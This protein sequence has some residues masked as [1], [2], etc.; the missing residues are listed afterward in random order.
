MKSWWEEVGGLEIDNNV[1]K[2]D[3]AQKLKW[4]TAVLVGD[5]LNNPLVPM[6]GR[7]G[8]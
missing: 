7:T 5:L 1:T 8:Q 6:V 4:T 2:V 3:V